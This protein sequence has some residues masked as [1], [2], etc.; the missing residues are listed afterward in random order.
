M[1]TFCIFKNSFTW[2]MKI[3]IQDVLL[4]QII[5][6]MLWNKNFLVPSPACNGSPEQ[7][8]AWNDHFLFHGNCLDSEKKTIFTILNSVFVHYNI[9]KSTCCYQWSTQRNNY[10]VIVYVLSYISCWL[11]WK[12]VKSMQSVQ[13]ISSILF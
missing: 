12:T 5:T 1:N 3:K 10:T 7:S 13:Y 2:N 11:P 4:Q 6:I 9:N 8:F